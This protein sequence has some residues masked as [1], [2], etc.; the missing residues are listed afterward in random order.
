MLTE[1]DGCEHITNI[2]VDTEI[3]TTMRKILVV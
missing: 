3:Q 1:K 2:S